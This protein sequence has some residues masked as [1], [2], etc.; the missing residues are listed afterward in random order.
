MALFCVILIVCLSLSVP[1][2][3]AL[4][5]GLALFILTALIQ[6]LPA[7]Q[8]L[9]MCLSG[10]KKIKNILITFVLIGLLTALWRASGCI[11]AIVSSVSGLM[12]PG[13]FLPL[14]FLLNAAVST[15]TGTSFGTSA[16]MG[17][18]CMSIAGA[19]GISPALSGGAVLSGAFCGDRCS[20][21]S[22]SALLVSTVTDTDIY[23][24]IR[25]MVMTAAVPFVLSCAF[26][27]LMGL[28]VKGDVSASNAVKLFDSEFTLNI[29][30]LL[31]AAIIAVLA[32]FRLNVKLLLL[33]SVLCALP[34]T[35]F[36]QH[37]PLSALP[38]LLIN[39]FTPRDPALINVIS[40]GGLRSMLRVTA[41]VLTASCYSGIFE[42]TDMLSFLQKPLRTLTEKH[43][44]YPAVL[45]S[46]LLSCMISCNQTLAIMLTHQLT[47]DFTD[48]RPLEAQYLENTVIVIAPLI[49]WSIAGSVPLA[50]IG[51]PTAGILFACYLFLI[52]LWQLFTFRRTES[53][54]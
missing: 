12:T 44:Y 39:G 33:T 51:A 37:M 25:R 53:R 1:I 20:P 18:I 24:N 26:Y 17:V 49:P 35:L 54:K 14:C 29:W 19:M 6:G 48:D 11:P 2:V 16:T 46:S 21:V 45:L 41:I 23:G 28:G 30:C 36:V 3:W 32:L 38:D 9:T 50:V 52:P 47:G 34:V 7:R 15:L 8:I 10:I 4:L 43:G 42:A 13:L 40:G 27:T 31:P 5:A 22:T